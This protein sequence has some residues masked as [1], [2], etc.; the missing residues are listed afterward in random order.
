MPIET[1]RDKGSA[2]MML[3]GPHDVLAASKIAQLHLER[4][5]VL[6]E[7]VGGLQVAMNDGEGV[8]VRDFYP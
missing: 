2:A 5:R 4:R 8:H 7:Y 1:G 3:N 6:D